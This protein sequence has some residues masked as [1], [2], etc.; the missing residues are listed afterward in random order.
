MEECEV[1]ARLEQIRRE[2]LERV[3]EAR[4]LL[5]MHG[6]DQAIAMSSRYVMP[7]I[8]KALAR[9]HWHWRSVERGATKTLE[10][11]I[12]EMAGM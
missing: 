6:S 12:D 8:E 9:E 5:E 7:R 10:D 3:E 4:D 11:V 2:I 1:A